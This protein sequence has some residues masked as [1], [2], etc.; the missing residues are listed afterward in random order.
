MVAGQLLALHLIKIEIFTKEIMFRFDNKIAIVTGGGSGI[1]KAIS[2]LFAQQGA[3]VY[4]L[5]ID[6]T[7]AKDTVEAIANKG[8]NAFYK[9]CSV[10]VLN[11]V[12]TAVQSIIADHNRIDIII[13]NA[14]IAHIGNVETT[15]PEDVERLLSVNVK[16]V[17][18][19]T[20]NAK[21]CH[22]ILG[23]GDR[24]FFLVTV[25]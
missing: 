18:F 12:N 5:D 24:P 8:R 10:A 21:T 14:G 9:K 7:N 23:M 20:G 13:N 19:W 4:I 11:E 17:C 6:E 16:G 2:E 25:A 22:N 15:R 3:M 1:G